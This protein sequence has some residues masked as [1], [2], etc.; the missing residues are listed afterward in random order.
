M[1]LSILHIYIYSSVDDELL[2]TMPGIW[3]V[4]KK[5]D[6]LNKSEQMRT[7]PKPECV[8]KAHFDGP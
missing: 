1:V 5:P 7:I 2:K 3:K 6:H 8:L 4:R